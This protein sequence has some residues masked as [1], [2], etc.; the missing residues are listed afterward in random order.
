MARIGVIINP[1]AKRNIKRKE[2]IKKR[3]DKLG[4]DLV[5]TRITYS[6]DEIEQAGK[7][8]LEQGIEILCV[9]GGDGTLS[10][11]LSR[12]VLL[13][14]DKP[15]P[16]V[17]TLKGGTM[18]VVC[19]SVGLTKKPE[20]E[21]SRLL[22]TFKKKRQLRTVER[23]SMVVEGRTGFIFGFGMS[24]NVLDIYYDGPGTGPIKAFKVVIKAILSTLVRGAYAKRFWKPAVGKLTIR[25]PGGE[26]REIAQ[27]AFSAIIASTV[28][29]LPIGA[30]PLYRAYERPR[31]MHMIAA[32]ISPIQIILGIHRVFMGRSWN[33]EKV[34]DEIT[35]CWTFEG[36]QGM[37]YTL[38]GELYN[39][40]HATTEINIGPR[41]TLI[42][43]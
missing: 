32:A 26:I 16:K 31:F 15:F 2:Q 12:L 37:I 35:D 23:D 40:E 34:I 27:T 6:I 7:S 42:S 22:K 28:R 33:N 10:V 14:G 24:A 39:T 38:D 25:K 21:M 41:F 43:K 18:N 9:C 8:F 4:G 17:M 13:W 30:K 29:N 1:F 11:T 20:R 5:D 36:Q 3:I 19:S